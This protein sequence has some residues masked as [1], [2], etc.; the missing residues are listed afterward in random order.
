MSYKIKKGDRVVYIGLFGAF[1]PGK[2]TFRIVSVSTSG[3]A[4]IEDSGGRRY[5]CYSYNLA[6]TIEMR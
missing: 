3:H 5:R 1:T 2:N 6:K 4:S